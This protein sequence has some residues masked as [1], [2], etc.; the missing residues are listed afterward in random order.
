MFQ[1]KLIRIVFFLVLILLFGYIAWITNQVPLSD[2]EYLTQIKKQPSITI[3][4][5]GQKSENG[6]I[7]GIQTYMIVPD[8]STKE[9]FY[10]KLDNYLSIAKEKNLLHLNSILVFPEH[11]GS[12]L[13]FVDEKKDVTNAETWENAV[14]IMIYSRISDQ[15]KNVILGSS[16]NTALQLKTLFKQK[17]KLM[18]DA[19]IQTFSKL[20]SQYKVKIIAGSIILPEVQVQNGSISI[21]GEKLYNYSFVFNS[22]GKI[23]DY[24]AKTNLSDLEK[25]ILNSQNIS[26]TLSKS[27]NTHLGILIS[28]DTIYENSFNYYTN[29][30]INAL[31]SPAF[32]F[33]FKGID[34]EHILPIHDIEIDQL[35]IPNFENIPN[36]NSKWLKHSLKNKLSQASIPLGIQVF[37]KGNL[38]QYVPDGYSYIIFDYNKIKVLTYENQPGLVS[39]WL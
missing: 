9:R 11:I 16:T 19:Y 34:W 5:H 7:L 24:T 22:K 30:N 2:S 6:N 29:K 27:K 39:I 12:L 1:S 25:H 3:L 35:P 26:K 21:I 4:E 8:Y 23:S 37:L 38:F 13:F 31:I 18:L 14:Q 36:L 32:S 33:N 28:N 15:L 17:S 10:K 20:S